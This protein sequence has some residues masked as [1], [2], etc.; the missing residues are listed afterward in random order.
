LTLQA[1]YNN[2]L[3]A[4]STYMAILHLSN[5]YV[6]RSG[7]ANARCTLNPGC[8]GGTGPN[9]EW[10]GLDTPADQLDP[11]KP[12]EHLFTKKIWDELH[13]GQVYPKSLAQPIGGQFAV[14]KER[15]RHLPKAQYV[16]YRNWL[17]W[18]DLNDA[19]SEQIMVSLRLPYYIKSTNRES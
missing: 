3:F 15:I 9:A 19:D 16:H 1:D 8:S 14:S 12:Y 17:M 5:A 2:E 18:T 6:T 4:D 7:Y 11:K 13:P 10:I